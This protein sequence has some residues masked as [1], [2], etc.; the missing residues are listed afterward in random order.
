MTSKKKIGI[1]VLQLNMC[2][3]FKYK[4]M[5]ILNYCE[6]VGVNIICLNETF[7]NE[8]NMKLNWEPPGRAWR[9]YRG[10]RVLAS[11][12]DQA[13]GGAAILVHSSVPSVQ[14][15][16]PVG[17][18]C[19]CVEVVRV[20]DTD[21]S[22]PHKDRIRVISVYA[23]PLR[24]LPLEEIKSLVPDKKN[25][26]CMIV[27]DFNAKHPMW[28]CSRQDERGNSL[29]ALMVGDLGFRLLNYG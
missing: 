22:K 24:E 26:M 11:P 25:G 17:C 20:G 18:E 16:V 1:K 27:G 12:R 19:V 9:M 3:G 23:S 7:L 15:D 10:D 5:N 4:Y 29:E 21:P 13:R 6:S 8:K 14:V 28:G 2:G